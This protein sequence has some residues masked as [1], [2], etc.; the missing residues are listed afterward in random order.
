MGSAGRGRTRH[1][2]GR[3]AVGGAC[4]TSAG[5]A[6]GGSHDPSRG[7]ANDRADGPVATFLL[8]NGLSNPS[9]GVPHHLPRGL[10]VGEVGHRQGQYR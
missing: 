1:A 5:L 2:A 7:I 8:L 4:V 3:I 6:G 9:G 10:G